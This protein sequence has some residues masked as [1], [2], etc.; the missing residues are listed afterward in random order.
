M[1]GQL[2]IHGGG[3]PVVCPARLSG[4]YA[5]A[6]GCYALAAMSWPLAAMS[7]PAAWVSFSWRACRSIVDYISAFYQVAPT[8]DC[9]TVATKNKGWRVRVAG[10]QVVNMGLLS[11]VPSKVHHSMEASGV[12]YCLPLCLP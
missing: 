9:H 12:V 8:S 1:V 5:L 4:C 7:W 6:A 2:V 10:V 11:A 3:S